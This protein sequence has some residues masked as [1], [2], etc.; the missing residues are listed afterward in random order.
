M[1]FGEISIQFLESKISKMTKLILFNI[2]LFCTDGYHRDAMHQIKDEFTILKKGDIVF[3][4]VARIGVFW[5]VSG[6][7]FYRFLDL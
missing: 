5:D 4:Y 6:V 7:F 1:L 2:N 3:V